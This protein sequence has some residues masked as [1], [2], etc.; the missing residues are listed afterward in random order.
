MHYVYYKNNFFRKSLTGPN[1]QASE[2]GPLHTFAKVKSFEK[3][4]TPY[5]AGL[6]CKAGPLA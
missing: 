4:R 3:I 2:A 1:G 6:A 5:G